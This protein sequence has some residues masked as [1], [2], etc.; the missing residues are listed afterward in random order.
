MKLKQKD[1]SAQFG[2][3]E[4][5]CW[6]LNSFVPKR[7]WKLPQNNGDFWGDAN[8][9]WMGRKWAGP[10]EVF[11]EKTIN[12]KELWRLQSLP[13]LGHFPVFIFI[14]GE[15]CREWGNNGLLS[16]KLVSNDYMS[17]FGAFPPPFPPALTLWPPSSLTLTPL[18]GF[19][20][21][22]NWFN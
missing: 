16:W 13:L 11:N 5:L 7:K 18:G 21:A 12:F 15:T 17:F 10:Q 3:S 2:L 8:V 20:W 4:C 6:R 9:N 1:K 14:V 19:P 22:S